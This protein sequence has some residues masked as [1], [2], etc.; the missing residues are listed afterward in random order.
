MTAPAP[1]AGTAP[2]ARRWPTVA[3]VALAASL[4]V[5]L[6]AGFAESADLAE[7]LT[8]AGVVYLG[9]AALRRR[10]AAWPLFA[11]T[12]VLITVGFLVP[13]FEPIWWLLG[14]AVALAVVGLVGGALRPPWGL[15]LQALALV[16]V[17][18]VAVAAT[19]ASGPWPGLLVGA[20]LLGHA[21]WDVYHHRTGRVVV[22]SMSEFCGVLDALLAV[23]VVVASLTL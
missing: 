3:G 4:A 20:G 21:A 13:A 6:W 5:A 17:A 15:P 14:L 22:R 7:V 10:A 9:A 23:A 16:A 19:R 12:F 18:A 11:A 8:A 1:A 2:S